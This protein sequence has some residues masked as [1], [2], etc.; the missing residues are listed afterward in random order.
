MNRYRYRAARSDGAILTGLVPSA[1]QA[2]AV[3]VL[4][5]QGLHPLA[6]ERVD[7]VEVQGR[8]AGRNDLAVFF[9]AL[10][11][12][13]TVGVP[14]D[15]ALSS[16]AAAVTGR[17]RDALP[18]IQRSLREGL[19]LSAA[20]D[21]ESGLV[22]ARLVSMVRAGERASRLTEALEQAAG[23]IEQEVALVGRIRQALLYP[24]VL[25]VTGLAS[26]TVI[27][28]VVLPRFAGL[29]ADLG[30]DLPWTTRALLS[31]AS[32]VETTGP[33]LPLMAAGVVALHRWPV[34]HLGVRCVRES[35]QTGDR[36]GGYV[37][38]RGD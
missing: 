25:L 34:H 29:L 28:F 8:P 32:F 9:R 26:V 13:A 7:E 11:S 22:P 35:C 16:T 21:R 27:A 12:L 38:S 20:L 37:G 14:I 31:A 30:Q 24:L 19:A 3:G 23:H 4:V 33:F 17:L 2:E 5:G 10:A 36:I 15:R 1:T 18:S 6:L